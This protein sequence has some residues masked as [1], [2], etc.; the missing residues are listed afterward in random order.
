MDP[1]DNNQQEYEALEADQG[2]SRNFKSDLANLLVDLIYDKKLKF[3]DK[4]RTK[5]NYEL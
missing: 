5:N 1:N 3:E 2:R 4:A